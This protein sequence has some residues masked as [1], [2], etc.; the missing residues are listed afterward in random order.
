MRDGYRAKCQYDQ[1]ISD[2][3]KAFEIKPRLSEACYYRA[4]AYIATDRQDE[5]ISG[6]TKALE[7]SP[8]LIEAYR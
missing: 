7:I 1:A 8:R 6:F 3:N 4:I 5:A 2:Y